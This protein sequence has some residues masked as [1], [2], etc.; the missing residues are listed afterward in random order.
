MTHS[1][2]AGLWTFFF[3]A[4]VVLSYGILGQSQVEAMPCRMA[5]RAAGRAAVTSTTSGLSSESYF[6]TNCFY[7]KTRGLMP[8]CLPTSSFH[9]PAGVSQALAAAPASPGP[10]ANGPCPP[11]TCVAVAR[12]YLAAVLAGKGRHRPH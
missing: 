9:L 5:W 11:H 2:A 4:R 8:L 7:P 12:R 3:H 6:L 1:I 10:G